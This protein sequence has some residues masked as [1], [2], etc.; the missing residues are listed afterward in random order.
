MFR[1]MWITFVKSWN[2]FLTSA[3]EIII[4]VSRNWGQAHKA[5]G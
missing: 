3:V 4:F 1:E 2:I 5:C